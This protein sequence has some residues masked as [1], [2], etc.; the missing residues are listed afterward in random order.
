M[1]SNSMQ[2]FLEGMDIKEGE[3]I[4]IN[5][6]R[7]KGIKKFSISNQ[8]GMLLYNCTGPLVILRAPTPQTC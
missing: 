6:P 5:C 8:D 3:S 7:C 2:D 4:T 1:P